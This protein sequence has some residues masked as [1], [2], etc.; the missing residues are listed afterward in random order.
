MLEM[1]WRTIDNLDL[2]VFEWSRTHRIEENI[3]HGL[4]WFSRLK[5]ML[6]ILTTILTFCPVPG[7]TRAL[8]MQGVRQ[9][10][11]LRFRDAE[12]DVQCLSETIHYFN[13]ISRFD[14]QC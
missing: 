7:P 6:S 13:S 3:S 5:Q 9:C 11:L 14:S 12:T 8:F 1:D 10:F 2:S 4:F